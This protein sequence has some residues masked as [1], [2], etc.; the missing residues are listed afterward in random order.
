MRLTAIGSIGRRDVELAMHSERRG[1]FEVVSAKDVGGAQLRELVCNVPPT[2]LA[3]LFRCFRW[4]PRN[5]AEMSATGP[6]SKTWP[7]ISTRACLP[8]CTLGRIPPRIRMGFFSRKL[9]RSVTS[10]QRYSTARSLG[11]E[12]CLQQ[13]NISI[14]RAD[15]KKSCFPA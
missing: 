1:S 7:C 13:P 5:V 15:A 14:V 6:I 12:H 4:I 11:S 10:Q 3:N 8:G 2:L 9:H